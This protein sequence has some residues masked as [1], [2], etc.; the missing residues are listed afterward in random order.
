MNGT[1]QNITQLIHLDEPIQANLILASHILA[2]ANGNPLNQLFQDPTFRKI[3][4]AI[5][6]L[7]IGWLVALFISNVI[8]GGLLKKTS[9]DNRI[10]GWVTGSQENGQDLPVEKSKGGDIAKGVGRTRSRSSL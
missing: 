7:F 2:Q 10:A 6:I 5:G 3:A 9:V 1:W 4:I 8:V